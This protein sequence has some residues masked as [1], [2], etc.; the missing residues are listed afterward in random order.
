[1]SERCYSLGADRSRVQSLGKHNN[2]QCQQRGH[3]TTPGPHTHG[4]TAPPRTLSLKGG[5]EG[6]LPST[7]GSLLLAGELHL[8]HWANRCRRVG[9]RH[10][11]TSF[12]EATSC[13][14][15][16]GARPACVSIN[17]TWE[18]RATEEGPG[19]SD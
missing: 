9:L 5:A 14:E 10:C 8:L 1:M 6:Q 7:P 16:K 12:H 17:W 4:Q 13:P 18:T 3:T 19:K 15:A 2:L 11:V